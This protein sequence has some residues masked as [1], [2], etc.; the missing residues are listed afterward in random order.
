MGGAYST[1]GGRGEAY[2]EFWWRQPEGKNYFE[3]P[4][5]NGKI[6]LK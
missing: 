5:V 1:C 6:I 3:D 4:G 2:T